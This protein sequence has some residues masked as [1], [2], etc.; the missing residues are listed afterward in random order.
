MNK[1]AAIQ[2]LTLARL[3][4]ETSNESIVG[5]TEDGKYIVEW[6]GDD[7]GDEK[8]ECTLGELLMHL[9]TVHLDMEKH[10]PACD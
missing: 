10:G 9:A 4:D 5:I 8:W 2:N 1:L 3:L 6:E 7:D